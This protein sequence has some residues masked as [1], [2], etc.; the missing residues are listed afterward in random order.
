[1]AYHTK[2]ALPQSFES[3]NAYTDTLMY[4]YMT[5]L[6]SFILFCIWHWLLTASIA[7]LGISCAKGL[8]GLSKTLWILSSLEGLL[9]LKYFRNAN[10]HGLVWN[11]LEVYVHDNF[12][13]F[14]NIF[15][16]GLYS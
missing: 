4:S 14:E 10:I 8:F 6:P 3:I 12:I 1:M 2:T 9:Q 5:Q 11:I 13:D 7:E 16:N 15:E